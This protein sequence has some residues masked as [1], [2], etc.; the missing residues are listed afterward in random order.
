MI[1]YHIINNF[2]KDNFNTLYNAIDE[3]VKTNDETTLPG[4]GVF[5]ELIWENAEQELKNERK[6]T[7]RKRIQKRLHNYSFYLINI[8]CIYFYNRTNC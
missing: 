4:L 7:S 8:S 2:K 6:E 3:A 5:L 1:R